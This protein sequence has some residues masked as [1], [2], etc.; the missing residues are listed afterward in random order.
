MLNQ[1]SLNQR[2]KEEKDNLD[3]LISSAKTKSEKLENEISFLAEKIK[4]EV[5]RFEAC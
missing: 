2:N 4:E 5:K 3:K 1:I